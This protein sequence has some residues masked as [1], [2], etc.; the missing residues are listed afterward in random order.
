MMQ[1]LEKRKYSPPF[2]FH[3]ISCLSPFPST[4]YWYVVLSFRLGMGEN[5]PFSAKNYFRS[6]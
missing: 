4:G 5:A 1:V 3:P 2:R 6:F